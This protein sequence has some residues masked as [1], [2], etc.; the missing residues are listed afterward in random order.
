LMDELRDTLGYWDRSPADRLRAFIALGELVRKDPGFGFRGKST[1]VEQDLLADW[2]RP[3]AWWMG[4]VQAKPPEP[5][6]LRAWQRFISDNLEFRLGVT[7]GA[8]VARAW[9]DG[10]ND[11]AAVPSLAEWKQTTGLPWFAFW[12]RELLRWGT[13]DPCVA[14]SMARGLAQTREVAAGIRGQ[15]DDWLRAEGHTDAEDFID[16]QRFLAW[17]ESQSIAR[18]N[19]TARN[20]S[21]CELTGT[22]GRNANYPVLPVRLN[23]AVVWV[24][25]SGYELGRTSG[26]DAP[27]TLSARHDYELKATTRGRGQVTRRYRAG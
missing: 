10:A 20:A 11:D 18:R 17:Q 27:Q 26:D 1:I 22:D 16:P 13:L 4:L 24:D 21:A 8:A 3:L 23:G 2:K 6:D 15:F 19:V 5:E 25:P 7:I 14:F 12:A 9:S